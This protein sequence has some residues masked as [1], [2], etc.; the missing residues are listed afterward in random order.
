M[1]SLDH[2]LLGA[3]TLESGIRWLHERTGVEAGV[4]GA[5]PGLGT[6]N[7][8]ASLGDSRY[9]E[10]IAPD[11]NQPG[12]DTFYVP[13][14]R[15][16]ESPRVATWA[17][18]ASAAFWQGEA[19]TINLEIVHRRDGSRVRPDGRVL[20]WRLAFVRHRRFGTFDGGLP[21]LID[22]DERSPHPGTTSAPGLRLSGFEIRH[23]QAEELARAL[24]SLDIDARVVSQPSPGLAVSVEGPRGR[25]EL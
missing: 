19:P 22:W 17:S 20:R 9:L 16:F 10:V 5:H 11:P 15:G 18:T 12:V 7:A 23:P 2:I 13:G 6:W 8:L 1:P 3:P 14:L 4:G 21:F 25:T 24:R